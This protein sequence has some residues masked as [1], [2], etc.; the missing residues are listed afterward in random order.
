MDRLTDH[1]ALCE[2]IS[3]GMEPK[4]RG[5]LHNLLQYFD[6]DD[7]ADGDKVAPDLYMELFSCV[8]SYSNGTK[9][10]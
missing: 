6:F 8:L 1:T 10:Y 5:I 2:L 9:K 4:N 3:F 7:A